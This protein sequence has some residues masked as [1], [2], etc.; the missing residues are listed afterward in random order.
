MRYRDNDAARRTAERRRR[1]DE[2]PRLKAEVPSLS[3]LDLEMSERRGSVTV[4]T[5]VKRVVV[6]SAPALFEI[7]CSDRSCKEGGHDL[8]YTIMRALR[9]QET[10]F[11]GEDECRG[12]V[13]TAPCGCVMRFVATAV[14]EG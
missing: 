11:E 2:A 6:A 8:T 4:S 3:R 10:R 7:A 12:R 9:S 14:F 1:E 5:H 13:G